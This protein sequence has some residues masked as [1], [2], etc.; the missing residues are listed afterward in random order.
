M[1]L[2]FSPVKE[3]LLRYAFEMR[4]IPFDKNDTL[5]LEEKSV[6]KVKLRKRKLVS[7]L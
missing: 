2:F 7:V 3:V 6:V 5:Q 1:T 4:Q